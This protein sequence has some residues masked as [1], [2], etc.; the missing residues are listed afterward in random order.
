MWLII[1]SNESVDQKIK[2]A[3]FYSYYIYN[4]LNLGYVHVMVK[5]FNTC[6][7]TFKIFN[8]CLTSFDLV[9]LQHNKHDAMIEIQF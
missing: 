4:I 5:V 8:Q 2:F 9:N 3:P 7:L 6:I 1:S